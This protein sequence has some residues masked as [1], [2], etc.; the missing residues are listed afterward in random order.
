MGQ[1][2][3]WGRIFVNAVEVAGLFVEIINFRIS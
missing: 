3:S 1:S 2:S